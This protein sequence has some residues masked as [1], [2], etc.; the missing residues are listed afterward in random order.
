MISVN[1]SFAKNTY[2]TSVLFKESI[3]DIQAKLDNK[4]SKIQKDR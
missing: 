4:N 1:V 3:I 2:K